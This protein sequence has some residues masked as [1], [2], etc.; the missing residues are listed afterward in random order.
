MVTGKP[1]SSKI[2]VGELQKTSICIH[3]AAIHTQVKELQMNADDSAP[4]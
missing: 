3:L 2:V 1:V 4:H